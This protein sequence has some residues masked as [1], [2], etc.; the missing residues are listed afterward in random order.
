MKSRYVIL[1]LFFQGFY[2]HSQA[3]HPF[4]TKCAGLSSDRLIEWNN[5]YLLCGTGLHEMA[6]SLTHFAVQFTVLD[7]N[8]VVLNSKKVWVDTVGTDSILNIQPYVYSVPFVIFK[9]HVVAGQILQKKNGSNFGALMYL[10]DSLSAALKIVRVDT[11]HTVAYIRQLIATSN[12]LIVFGSFQEGSNLGTTFI[13][14]YDTSFTLKW[15]KVFSMSYGNAYPGH[16]VQTPTGFIAGIEYQS[17][18]IGGMPS[19]YTGDVLFLDSM[20]NKT[21]NIFL[22]NA[23]GSVNNIRIAPIGS[24]YLVAWNDDYIPD[25]NKSNGDVMPNDSSTIWAMK[26]DA[27]GSILWKTNFQ[28][29]ISKACG[30]IEMGGMVNSDIVEVPGP[31]VLLVGDFASWPLPSI[32]FASKIDSLGKLRWFRAFNFFDSSNY[33]AIH[34]QGFNSIIRTKDNQLVAAMNYISYP[35]QV[36]PDG[37]QA[38]FAIKFGENGCIGTDCGKYALNLPAINSTQVINLS[39]F[40]NPSRGQIH[41]EGLET[42]KKLRFEIFSSTGQLVL[43]GNIAANEIDVSS[44]S[45]GCYHIKI[46]DIK[47]PLEAYSA[48][49]DKL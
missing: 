1:L 6:D 43:M 37:I 10:D 18:F 34:Y 25:P 41:I 9:N 15:R 4:I 7:T 13:A 49:F 47:S 46:V 26:I 17:N 31:S 27:K 40:P 3:Q 45:P 14:A 38:P 19:R 42:E 23:N 20:G 30:P 39:V 48:S 29:I 21:R 11:N 33:D 28:K 12:E 36:F 16:V 24:K 35:T 5:K 44:L 32:A 8:G 2:F 22:S